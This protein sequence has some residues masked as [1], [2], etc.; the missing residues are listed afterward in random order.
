MS[1][2]YGK[3]KNTEPFS[4]LGLFISFPETKNKIQSSVLKSHMVMLRRLL[5]GDRVEKSHFTVK[6]FYFLKV[7]LN[8]FFEHFSSLEGDDE[9]KA[10]F[11]LSDSVIWI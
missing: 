9:P 11:S 10:P 4:S 2:V 6:K 5:N 3:K 8:S 7:L 1:G